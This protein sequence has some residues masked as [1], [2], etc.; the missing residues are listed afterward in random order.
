MKSLASKNPWMNRSHSSRSRADSGSDLALLYACPSEPKRED[1]RAGKT[2]KSLRL[3]LRLPRPPPRRKLGAGVN[4]PV[5]LTMKSQQLNFIY[6]F[7]IY[8]F[9]IYLLLWAD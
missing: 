5:R 2:L 9:F 8:L 4:S 3:S 6:L 1:S 7:F